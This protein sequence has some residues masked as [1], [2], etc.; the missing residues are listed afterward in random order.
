MSVFSRSSWS[1]SVAGFTLLACAAEN[2]HDL[3]GGEATGGSRSE[4]RG[5]DGSEEP[6]SG[7][8]AN[9]HAG[10]SSSGGGGPQGAGGSTWTPAPVDPEPGAS[11]SVGAQ[12]VPQEMRAVP[13]GRCGESPQ[14]CNQDCRWESAGGCFNEAGECSLGTS[15]L[16]DEG[17]EPGILRPWSCGVSCSWEPPR[18]S[19]EMYD[20]NRNGALLIGTT[21]GESVQKT[22]YQGVETSARLSASVGR[23]CPLVPNTSTHDAYVQVFNPN[24]ADA[25]VHFYVE[26]SADRPGARVTGYIAAYAE[27]P[28]DDDARKSCLSGSNSG[29][30]CPSLA[31]AC[32]ENNGKE[33]RAVTI[34]AGGYLWV[35][36]GQYAAS[37]EPA[38]FDLKATVVRF[39]RPPVQ[40]GSL[41]VG[42]RLGE[43]STI[44]AFQGED[45]I[46]R[47]NGRNASGCT[48]SATSTRHYA[49]VE[50]KNPNASAVQVSLCAEKA[51]TETEAPDGYIAAYSTHPGENEALRKAC[52]PGS[53]SPHYSTKELCIKKKSGVADSSNVTIPAGS[54]VWVYVSRGPNSSGGSDP[55]ISFVLRAQVVSF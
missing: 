17:C 23:E 10:G 20:P 41:I 2:P 38:V 33:S 52:L 45:Q 16:R 50:V 5:D 25:T 51:E 18:L 8:G 42:S 3:L 49:Y 47:L 1:L 37:D 53:E 54:S 30:Y 32:L 19:C 24:A 48:L 15:E 28:V 27:L 40:E 14:V 11:C 4:H 44:V 6:S 39:E 46:P 13:C 7:G 35:Y 43:E 55:G 29:L 21:E 9:T 34:P 31:R 26:D 22:F 36:V 12:C